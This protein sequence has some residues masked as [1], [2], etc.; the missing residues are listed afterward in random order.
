MTHT[1]EFYPETW[2][3]EYE[4]QK[5]YKELMHYLA[6]MT[7][8]RNKLKLALLDIKHY[9]ESQ[10]LKL[11]WTALNVLEIINEVLGEN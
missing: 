8:Q 7:E 2:I 5:L 4:K 9:C 11:D 6:C 1:N 3:K 10:N